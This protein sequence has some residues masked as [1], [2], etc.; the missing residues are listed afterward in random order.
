ME[1]HCGM[2]DMLDMGI[3]M[4]CKVGRCC[5]LLL[6][7]P[8]SIGSWGVPKLKPVNSVTGVPW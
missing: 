8:E 1:G 4:G 6:K 3:T 7:A 5:T 2:A